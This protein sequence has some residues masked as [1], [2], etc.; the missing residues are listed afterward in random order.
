MD[1]TKTCPRRQDLQ[2]VIYAKIIKI[3]KLLWKRSK[4]FYVRRIGPGSGYGS[5]KMISDPIGTRTIM[6]S[7]VFLLLLSQMFF[8]LQYLYIFLHSGCRQT[9]LFP[10]LHVPSKRVISSLTYNFVT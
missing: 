6:H 9:P 5:G 10:I 4:N 1:G 7:S 2:Y 3:V 8:S